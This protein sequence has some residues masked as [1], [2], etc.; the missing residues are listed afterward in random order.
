MYDHSG[1]SGVAMGIAGFGFALILTG[2]NAFAFVGIPHAAQAFAAYWVVIAVAGLGCAGVAKG[3][4]KLVHVSASPAWTIFG[5]LGIVIATSSISTVIFDGFGLS[6][7]GCCGGIFMLFIGAYVFAQISDSSLG[8]GFLAT[9]VFFVVFALFAVP[10]FLSFAIQGSIP[11]SEIRATKQLSP[12]RAKSYATFYNLAAFTAPTRPFTAHQALSKA[13]ALLKEQEAA[14][15]DEEKKRVAQRQA[16]AN[17]RHQ[18]EQEALQALPPVERAFTVLAKSYATPAYNDNLK[19]L[20][21]SRGTYNSAEF[22]ARFSQ[23]ANTF[24]GKRK[25]LDLTFEENAPELS[26]S[27]FRSL[28]ADAL[29]KQQSEEIINSYLFERG[30]TGPQPFRAAYA[31]SPTAVREKLAQSPAK[32]AIYLSLIQGISTNESGSAEIAKAALDIGSD[33]QREKV[34]PLIFTPQLNPQTIQVIAAQWKSRNP[35]TYSPVVDLYVRIATSSDENPLDS[36]IIEELAQAEKPDRKMKGRIAALLLAS[37]RDTP[38]TAHRKALVKWSTDETRRDIIASLMAI[39]THDDVRTKKGDLLL[40]QDLEIMEPINK[41]LGIARSTDLPSDELLDYLKTDT[42]RVEQ[43]L[44]DAIVQRGFKLPDC[45]NDIRIM[46]KIGWKKSRQGFGELYRSA[47][48]LE[49]RKRFGEAEGKVQ[50]HI[51]TTLRLFP[52][53]N[54]DKPPFKPNPLPG[55][56]T[57][58]AQSAASDSTSKEPLPTTERSAPSRPTAPESKPTPLAPAG[59][60]NLKLAEGNVVQITTLGATD[61][62]IITQIEP[63]LINIT[64]I[65]NDKKDFIGRERIVKVLGS[66]DTPGL[67][68]DIKAEIKKQAADSAPS[69]ARPQ[70]PAPR[71]EPDTPA[72]PAR[73]EAPN[74]NQ[75]SV[76]MKVEARKFEVWY[77]A[78]IEK[79][80]AN[81]CYVTFDGKGGGWDGWLSLADLRPKGSKKNFMQ[82]SAE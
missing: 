47:K 71:N 6:G 56:S 35:Q 65:K 41:L 82:L 57:S 49:A 29:S 74:P 4:N 16:E 44:I 13:N 64:L 33:Q 76:G 60:T 34:Y 63:E 31:A 1:S 10:L 70:R 7:G 17:A 38:T 46:E 53:G 58:T 19:N 81:Q 14:D 3:V 43:I 27:V 48:T 42:L 79:I 66:V 59:N 8:K 55:A 50:R 9:I 36:Q 22:L 26:A 75:P 24:Q 11:A 30:I 12:E 73:P 68:D 18:A 52:N 69:P 72:E 23:F 62:A 45:E 39:N 28:L 80:G 21:R 32:D 77:E 61:Y 67:L 78:T 37:Y 54:P 25:L 2:L 20:I 5:W 51:A 15:A 40:A